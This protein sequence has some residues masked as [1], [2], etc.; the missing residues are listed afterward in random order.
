MAMPWTRGKQIAAALQGTRM[1][2]GRPDFPEPYTGS[3]TVEQLTALFDACFRIQREASEAAGRHIP[4]VVENVKGAQPWVGAARASFGS[5]Y[6]WGD[7]DTV[8]ARIIV[9]GE[10]LKAP[11]RTT[12]RSGRNFHTW[13][14]SGGTASSP[15]YNG[16]E[17][18][19]RGVGMGV[20]QGGSGAAW[21]REP[22]QERRKQATAIKNGGDWFGSGENMSAQRRASSGSTS[23]KAA[24]A[25]IAKIPFE[26]AYFVGQAFLPGVSNAA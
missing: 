10:E 25:L 15:S 20:K 17:H 2:F 26:L 3:R 16:A 8:G 18:E 12:K 22:L 6:L 14:L 9:R 1:K 5:Y 13:E 19:E 24:S 21:W 23:R 11:A 7:I 4:M